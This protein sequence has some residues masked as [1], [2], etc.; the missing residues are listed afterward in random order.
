MRRF[1]EIDLGILKFFISASILSN[2][3]LLNNRGYP[4]VR[5]KFQ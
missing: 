2:Y 3:V 1:H 4:L 5:Q